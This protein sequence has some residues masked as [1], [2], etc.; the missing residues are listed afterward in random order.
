MIRNA[1]R[2]DAS[3]P[4]GLRNVMARLRVFYS[5]DVNYAIES[6]PGA[7]TTITVDIPRQRA[8]E[9]VIHEDHDL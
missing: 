1:K 8:E 7:G 3:T 4:I 5:G 9:D 2:D 6:A